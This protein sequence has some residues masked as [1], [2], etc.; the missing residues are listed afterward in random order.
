GAG[1][2]NFVIGTNAATPQDFDG[3]PPGSIDFSLDMG[4]AGLGRY[5]RSA[6]EMIEMEA[7]ARMFDRRLM[8]LAEGLKKYDEN[9][10]RIKDAAEGLVKNGSALF[11][12]A[13]GDVALIS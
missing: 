12:S 7:I 13:K 9:A 6:P 4:Q 10:Y 1:G 8:A 11:D 3:A 5:L 2:S